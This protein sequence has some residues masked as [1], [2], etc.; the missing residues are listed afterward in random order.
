MLFRPF[1][2]FAP[3]PL[4]SLAPYT[5][6]KGKQLRAGMGAQKVPRIPQPESQ[7]AKGKY[8]DKIGRI[9]SRSALSAARPPKIRKTTFPSNM[10]Y[11]KI[12]TT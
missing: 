8:V 1:L 6:V 7:K 9:K 12:Q 3:E 2:Y 4:S 11:I 10:S 5:V